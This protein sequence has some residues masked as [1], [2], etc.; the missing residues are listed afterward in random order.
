MQLP[1]VPPPLEFDHS[2]PMRAHFERS[3]GFI[4]NN[5]CQHV[6][7]ILSQKPSLAAFADTSGETALYKALKETNTSETIIY[8]LFRAGYVY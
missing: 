5:F 8:A 7:D 2:L 3:V 4:A 1:E 6:I